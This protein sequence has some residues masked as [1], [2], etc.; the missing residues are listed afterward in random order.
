MQANPA[1]DKSGMKHEDVKILS[2]EF[3]LPSKIIYQLNSEF[4]CL[5]SIAKEREQ[6]R[7]MYG[8]RGSQESSVPS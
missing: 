8:R 5:K 3:L 6:Q 2:E 4:N 7:L 1:K